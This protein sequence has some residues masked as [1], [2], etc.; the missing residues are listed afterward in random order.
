MA[1]TEGRTWLEPMPAI[2]C[3]RHLREQ[4]LGR[5][6]VFVD[7][8]PEIFPVN[9]TFVDGMIVIR[10]D[11]GTKLD[12]IVEHPS[13]AFEIDGIDGDRHNGWSVLVVGGA[14]EVSDPAERQRLAEHDWPEPWA[15]GAKD[16]VICI[17]PEKTTG[18]YLYHRVEG[19]S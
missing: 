13:V 5:L 11:P 16:H 9:Y 2:A 14:R 18:R 7:G 10:V 4:Q 3:E 17:D 1:A 12:A 8:H 19:R 15:P 6:G